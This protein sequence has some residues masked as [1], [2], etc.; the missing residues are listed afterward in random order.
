[1]QLLDV[2]LDGSARGKLLVCWPLRVK[3]D[4]DTIYLS[5]TTLDDRC[6]RPANEDVP[7]HVSFM[8]VEEPSIT[9]KCGN[10]VIG[11]E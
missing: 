5:I 8:E 7:C 4:S 9:K 11:G 10:D 2:P 3:E 1:M 6:H